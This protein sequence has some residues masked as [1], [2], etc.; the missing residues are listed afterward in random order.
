[1]R[2]DY[3]NSEIEHCI[4]EYIHNKTHREMLKARFIDGMTFCELSYSFHL[5]ERQVK[6]IVYKCGDQL[7][8]KLQ[9]LKA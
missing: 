6:K 1:M 4:D 2:L 7:L 3:S 8:Q 5:S 9:R